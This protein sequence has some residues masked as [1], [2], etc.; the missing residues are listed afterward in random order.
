MGDDMAD[1]SPGLNSTA[2]TTL[3]FLTGRDTL[4]ADSTRVLPFHT[5][6]TVFSKEII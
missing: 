1:A 4:H 2:S 3:E 5:L 6:S